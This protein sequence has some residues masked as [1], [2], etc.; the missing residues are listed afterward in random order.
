LRRGHIKAPGENR[1]LL[2]SILRVK[3]DFVKPNCDLP[4]RRSVPSNIVSDSR[5]VKLTLTR[6]SALA[7]ILVVVFLTVAPARERPF[8]GLGQIPEHLLAFGL[9]GV[10]VALG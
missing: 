10:T 4:E 5:R 2:G 7:A 6:S 9:V 1:F 8:T 3:N